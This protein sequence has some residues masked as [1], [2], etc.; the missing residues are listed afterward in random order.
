MKRRIYNIVSRILELNYE[1][2]KK[3]FIFILFTIF[4]TT[5]DT[6]KLLKTCIVAPIE[7]EYL[8][9][10]L[11]VFKFYSISIFVTY[12][13]ASIVF[14]AK[15]IWIKYLL[16]LIP[17]SLFIINYFLKENFGNALDPSYFIIIGETNYN[18]TS[19]FLKAFLFTWFGLKLSIITIIIVGSIYIAE[20]LYDKLT[21]PPP[22]C[23]V[24]LI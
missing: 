16:Y 3:E 10:W 2:I 20:K 4:L 5:I 9:S 18:E 7:N 23:K 12:M 24:M 14:F 8:K 21:L 19:E 17:L 1:I 15:K 13:L 6:Q 22:I 11:T